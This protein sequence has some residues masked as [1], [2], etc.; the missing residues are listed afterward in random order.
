MCVHTSS[1]NNIV[2]Y[3]RTCRWDRWIGRALSPAL[4]E[5]CGARKPIPKQLPESTLSLSRQCAFQHPYVFQVT[6]AGQTACDHPYDRI[7]SPRREI[8][9]K[10]YS[11]TNSALLE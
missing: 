11:S 8:R 7:G 3:Q 1:G 9:E 5:A 2:C 6:D 10:H 4:P